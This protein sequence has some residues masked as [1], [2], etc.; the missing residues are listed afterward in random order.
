MKSRRF[1][2]EHCLFGLALVLALIIRLWGLGAKPLSDFEAGWAIQALSVAHGEQIAFG[3]QPG[4]IF[5]TGLMFWLMGSNEFL[6]RLWPAL[7]G[8][9][10]VLVPFFLR[11]RLGHGAALVAAFGLAFDPGL[12]ALSRLAG[13]TMPAIGFGLL[14]LS[15][16]FEQSWVATGVFAG[17]ALLSGPAILQGLLILIFAWGMTKILDK[18]RSQSFRSETSWFNAMTGDNLRRV[19]ITAAGVILLVGTLFFRYPQ[20]LGAW[21]SALPA[22]IQ[23]WTSTSDIPWQ[24]FLAALVVYQPLALFFGLVGAALAWT[25]LRDGAEWVWLSIFST[26]GLVAAIL[27]ALVTPGR[28]IADLGW[29]LAL[30]WILAGIGMASIC[31]SEPYEKRIVIG[32]AMAFFILMAFLWLQLATISQ[33]IPGMRLDYVR[34]IV[35]LA[36]ILLGGLLTWLVSAGWSWRVARLGLAFGL[37]CSLGV[38]TFSNVWGIVQLKQ[39]LQEV[40][41]QELWTEYPLTGQASLLLNTIGDLS[42]WKTGRREVLDIT[43]AVDVPSIRWAL[44]SFSNIKFLADHQSLTHLGEGGIGLPSLILTRQEDEVPNLT[45]VYRGE[46]FGWWM[47]PDWPGALPPDFLRWLVFRQAT[48]QTEQVI[49]WARGDLFPG[50]SVVPTGSEN[51]P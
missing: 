46:G 32:L 13:G 28:S 18:V 9:L 19:G 51:A 43:V 47:R 26:L 22:Y 45:V 5:P 16:A 2:V 1:T 34:L 44:R 50:G 48:W 12:V 36:L 39:E 6:A 20:G 29:V 15:L 14:A 35:F 40:E 17:L 33:L 4:Y 23:T 41:R 21:V 49:L 7:A 8:S 42:E 10:L 27:I 24:R 37:A 11:N 30:L 25:H 38:Y 31:P 3:A